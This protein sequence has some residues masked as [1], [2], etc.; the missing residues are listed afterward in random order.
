MRLGKQPLMVWMCLC[1]ARVSSPLAFAVPCAL[2]DE[3]GGRCPFCREGVEFAISSIAFLGGGSQVGLRPP[4]SS[5]GVRAKA[6]LGLGA[7][8]APLGE[9]L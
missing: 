7:N 5:P 4:T 2:G 8:S 9:R 6:P 1:G 3:N